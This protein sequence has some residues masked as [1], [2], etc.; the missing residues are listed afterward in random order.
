V[1]HPPASDMTAATSIISRMARVAF[2]D[3]LQNLA[4]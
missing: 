1:A 4:P 3:N 2:I